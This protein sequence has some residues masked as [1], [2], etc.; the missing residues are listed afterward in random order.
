MYN[1][2]SN[3]NTLQPTDTQTQGKRQKG[4][5]FTNISKLLGANIGAGKAMGEQIGGGVGQQAGK[6][7]ASA[8]ASTNKFLGDYA[9]SKG[10]ALNTLSNIGGLA[11]NVG[12]EG[13][14]STGS[15]LGSLSE[16]QAA[17]KGREFADLG[18]KGP[19]SLAGSQKLTSQATTLGEIGKAAIGG[20]LGQKSLL[21]SMVARPGQYTRGQSTL[22]ATLIGQSSQAQQAMQQGAQQAFQAQK[23]IAAQQANAAN[24][25]QQAGATIGQ[26]KSDV[27]GQL[28]TNLGNIQN[29]ATEQAKAHSEIGSTMKGALVKL[30]D[31]AQRG[32]LSAAEKAT[33][34]QLAEYGIDP[35]ALVETGVDYTGDAESLVNTI[36]NQMTP[37]YAGGKYYKDD[38]QNAARNLALMTQQGTLGSD[39]G[40]NTYDPKFT[41]VT[42]ESVLNSQ[43]DIW[44]Q[45]RAQDAKT[46]EWRNLYDLGR[47]PN[48]ISGATASIGGATASGIGHDYN[49]NTRGAFV[50][51]ARRMLGGNTVDQIRKYYYDQT[52]LFGSGRSDAEKAYLTDINNR[53]VGNLNAGDAAKGRREITNLGDYLK[54]LSGEDIAHTAPVLAGDVGPIVDPYATGSGIQTIINR[55]GVF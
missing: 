19:T 55:P 53:I 17:Q 22:D 49:P 27:G 46:A 10:S 3:P 52:S 47:L 29:A 18:Y 9:T 20:T 15:E 5:G 39:I 11:G 31:P 45:V 28:L 54:R 26:Q 35:N 40:K 44:D 50:S 41:N 2:Q 25:A 36:A 32:S 48:V 12:T 4:S 34:S 42:K 43:K 6:V 30:A 51:E 8:D 13:N 7:V 24:L 16:G 33:L 14:V 21:Q 38:Q 1:Q 37:A 23:N